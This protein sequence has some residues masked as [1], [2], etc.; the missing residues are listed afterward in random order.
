MCN[1][2]QERKGSRFQGS[3]I[4]GDGLREEAPPQSLSFRKDLNDY[5]GQAILDH[6]C[7]L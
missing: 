3:F 2:V 4:R 6:F 7:P 5:E 1:A